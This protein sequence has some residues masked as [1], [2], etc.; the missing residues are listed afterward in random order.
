[1]NLSGFFSFEGR[2]RRLHFW[3]VRLGGLAALFAAAVVISLATGMEAP[4]GGGPTKALG[5]MLV[6]ALLGIYLWVEL[7]NVVR[8]CHDRD[9]SGFFIFVGLIPLIGPIWL[10]IEL[11]F[12]DGTPGKNRYGPSPKHPD[13]PVEVFA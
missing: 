2:T 12:L 10:L 11:G 1:V 7:A 9:K 6:L 8:R 5:T 4:D 13:T 3:L